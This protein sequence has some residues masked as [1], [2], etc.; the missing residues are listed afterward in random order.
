MGSIFLV[1]QT[2]PDKTDMSSSIEPASIKTSDS[3]WRVLAERSLTGLKTTGVSHSS[4]AGAFDGRVLGTSLGA[5][6]GKS[7][8]MSDGISDW[9][10][11][12]VS[13][14]T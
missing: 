14:G 6:D 12:G 7:D 13:L 3:P 9:S 8:G 11:L 5:P 4:P 10:E 2:S 1:T